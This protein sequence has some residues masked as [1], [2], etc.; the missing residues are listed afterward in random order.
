MWPKLDL[1]APAFVHLP[2][3][4]LRPRL[5]CVVGFVARLGITFLG[6]VEFM[7]VCGLCCFHRQTDEIEQWMRVTSDTQEHLAQERMVRFLAVC[8]SV[9]VSL[10][11]CDFR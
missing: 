3:K 2:V 8:L 7:S 4:D 11:L 6:A 1:V 10:S 9:Y 5:V